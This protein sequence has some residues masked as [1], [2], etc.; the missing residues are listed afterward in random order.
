MRLRSRVM[1][2]RCTAA[3]SADARLRLGPVTIDGEFAWRE[4]EFSSPGSA[5]G[6]GHFQKFGWLVMADW[7]VI[8]GL[9]LTGA[10]DALYVTNIFLGSFGPTPNPAVAITDD[11]N[12][13]VRILGGVSYTTANFV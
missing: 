7:Q 4:T 11:K 6:E 9:H 13:I 10:V 1:N 12:R 5:G 8:S 2:R 3:C